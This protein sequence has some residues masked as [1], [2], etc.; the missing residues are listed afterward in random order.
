MLVK[1]TY[2][3]V[4]GILH[5]LITLRRQSRAEI[6]EC[7]GLIVGRV[8]VLDE[9]LG[10]ARWRQ[11]EGVACQKIRVANVA[12]TTCQK[13]SQAAQQR[14]TV[15]PKTHSFSVLDPVSRGGKKCGAF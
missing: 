13:E 5:D 9:D 11:H 15:G 4:L 14:G 8:S 12:C 3:A 6:G 7:D 1:T 10:R 2:C